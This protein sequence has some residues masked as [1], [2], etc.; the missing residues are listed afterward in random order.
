MTR[1]EDF[2]GAVLAGVAA[3]WHQH[4][5]VRVSEPLHVWITVEG[6]G[7]YRFHTSGGGS[8]DV[9]AG[10][11]HEDYD[12][13]PYGE[14]SVEW[15]TPLPL[16]ERVGQR[17]EGVSRLRQ[18]PPGAEVGVALHF[19]AGAVAVA[20]SRRR[21]G[22]WV[23]AWRRLVCRRGGRGRLAP[24]CRSR[25][26][27]ARDFRPMRR[28]LRRPSLTRTGHYRP[29]QVGQRT[30]RE[31]PLWPLLPREIGQRGVFFICPDGTAHTEASICIASGRRSEA[32][33]AL[34][35]VSRRA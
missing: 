10:V 1:V 24:K 31:G 20:K 21:P 28:R 32:A 19:A 11:P 15:G 23:L 17:I 22:C 33:L 8:L 12:M 7:T 29:Q 3:S 18:D 5:G 27:S 4:S 30:V 25:V 16:G 14:V 35:T 2:S 26:G 9:S 13:E 34:L 6:Q